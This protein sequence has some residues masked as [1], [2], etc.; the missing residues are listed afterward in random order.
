[1]KKVF[2]LLLLAVAASLCYGQS[3]LV[4]T[5]APKAWVENIAFDKNAMPAS[6]QERSFYYLLL[7]DQENFNTHEQ[8]A[9]YAYKILTTEGLQDM[10]DLSFSFDPSYEQLIF[11]TLVIH[12]GDSVINKL[13]KTFKTDSAGGKYGPVYL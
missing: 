10:A 5:G 8:Y 7:D 3:S 1:M 12:R 4:K 6:G 2:T 11:H 13:P 9:H